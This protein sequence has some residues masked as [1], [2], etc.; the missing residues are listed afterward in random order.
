M[1]KKYN[2]SSM[3]CGKKTFDFIIY[4]FVIFY[5]NRILFLTKLLQTALKLP[6]FEKIAPPQCE[7]ACRGPDLQYIYRIIWGIVKLMNGNKVKQNYL[8][9][10]C[11]KQV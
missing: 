9:F 8:D 7:R 4:Y 6:L 5:Y 2:G 1:A 11:I 10:V 3:I